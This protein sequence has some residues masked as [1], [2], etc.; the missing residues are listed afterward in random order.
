M[1][2]FGLSEIRGALRGLQRSPVIALS[3]VAC[4]ALGL[5]STA[6]ISSAVDRALVQRLPF[7]APERIVTVYRSTPHFDNGPFSPLNYLDLARLSSSVPQ[8]AAI[9]FGTALL[10]L[11]NQATQVDLKRAS[12]NLF[13]MLGVSALRGRLILPEDDGLDREPVAVLSAEFWQERF[14]GDPAIV[15]R[16]IRLDG[17]PTTVVGILPSR[18]GVPHGS[19]VARAQVWVPMRFSEEERTWRNNNFLLVM[20]RLRDGV[21]PAAAQA[22][23]GRLFAAIV[24]EHPDLRGQALRVLPLQTEGTRTVR[25]PLL[26]IFAAAAI[27]L[28]I[29][30]VNVASLLLARGVQRGREVAIRTALGGT[31][32]QVMRPAMMETAVLTTVG[33]GLGIVLAWVGVRSIGDMA[34]QRL[35]QLAGLAINIRIVFFAVGLAILVAL[36]A[37]LVPAWRGAAADPLDAL[38]GG[39]GG[40]TGGAHHRLLGALVV[41]EVALSLVLLIGAGLVLRGFASLLEQE[42]GFDPKRILTLQATVSPDGYPA[43]TAVRRYLEP[44]LAAVRQVTGVEEAAAIS[45]LPYD[46]WGWN[47]NIRYE[48][49]SDDPTEQPLV[50]NRIVTPEFF[51]VTGQHLLDGRLLDAGDGERAGSPAVVV[52]NRTLAL[53][54]FPGAS[55]IGKRYYLDDTTFATIVGVVTDIRNAGPYEA[56]RAEVYHSFRQD[57]EGWWSFSLMVRTREGAGSPIDPAAL[58]GPVTAALRGVDPQ[59][60]VTAV[61]P[62][63]DVISES[64]GRPRFYLALLGTFGAVALALAVAG[65]YGVL[66]YAVAQRTREFGIRAA[67]G[68]SATDILRLVTRRAVRLLAIGI[69]IGLAGSLA[70]TK[71]LVS[72]LY[73]VSPLD[74]GAWLAATAT[75]ALAGFVA[76]LLPAWR[77][78]RADPVVALRAE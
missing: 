12:G 1:S 40:G 22:E 36:L 65:I 73:G 24:A 43:G 21:A 29:A 35:P 26:L 50:E 15:G 11:P 7:K 42:P 67:L 25:A 19:Q 41:A 45:L 47:F 74:A 72:L 38:R 71:L 59:G 27:V 62:M 44:A 16:T 18:F 55:P 56:P 57:G 23:L 60:A 3:A 17:V 63:T 8:L 52:V 31:R 4:I 39:R 6:A 76:A 69:A 61:R 48:G 54:D 70:A 20:G 75:L 30:A 49:R 53:R 58:A 77:A 10:A 46:R 32:G 34:A 33:L 51:R 37:G 78:T 28:L 13:P 5:G 9:G 14:G 66:S 2:P 68:S 64:L